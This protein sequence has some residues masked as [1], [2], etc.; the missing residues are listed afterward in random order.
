MDLFD[1]CIPNTVPCAAP[2][3]CRAQQ[4]KKETKN[5]RYSDNI[6]ISAPISF[7]AE[8]GTEDQRYHLRNRLYNIYAE[9][10]CE[11]GE[12]FN[13]VDDD[14]PRTPREMRERINKGL[15]VING[16]DKAPDAPFTWIGATLQWRDPQKPAD[17]AGYEAALD[18]AR[19]ARTKTM[20]DITIL[21]PKDGLNSLREFEQA[22]FH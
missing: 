3:T 11:L 19:D 5:M 4:V 12:A 14:A 16:E 8:D 17:L 18:K 6:N 9:K 22:T 1:C 7:T 13:L 15:F 10:E 20:D 2:G 21:D